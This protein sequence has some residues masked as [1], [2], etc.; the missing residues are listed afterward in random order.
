MSVCLTV[1]L[2]N[3][4]Q[5]SLDC[6]IK[7]AN[8]KGNQPWI[9]FG[10]TDAEAE[11]PVLWHLMQRVDHR[12]RTWC[13]ERLKAGDG[14]Y[15]GWDGLMAS[16]IQ[17]TRVWASSGRWWWTGRPGMLLSM[18]SHRVRHD[19]VT[20]EQQQQQLLLLL[21]LLSRFCRVWLCATPQTAAH[22]TPPSL[23]FSRQ[24]HWSGVPLP[25]PTTTAS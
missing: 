18:G 20:E 19:W 5:S 16:P 11:T 15:R 10:R 8:P 1:M 14:G 4:L 12:K 13:W 23:G 21:L 22:Q 17:W 25:S 2:K 9:S 7:A 6:K 3:T 24:E